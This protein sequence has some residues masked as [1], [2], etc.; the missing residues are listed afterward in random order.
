MEGAAG[1]V[2]AGEGR[3][4]VVVDGDDADAEDRGGGPRRGGLR[5][6]LRGGHGRRRASWLEIGIVRRRIKAVGVGC[7]VG[8]FQRTLLLGGGVCGPGPG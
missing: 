7:L 4:H 8:S 5:R 3:R 6:R 2:E 1:E